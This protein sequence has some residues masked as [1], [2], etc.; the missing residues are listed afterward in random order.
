MAKNLNQIESLI[1]E[2]RNQKVILD[3]D[4]A[5]IY[6]VETRDIIKRLKII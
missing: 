3:S 5:S 1:I 2:L 4:V 6:G